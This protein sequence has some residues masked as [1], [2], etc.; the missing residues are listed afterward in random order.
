MAAEVDNGAEGSSGFS[1]S[2]LQERERRGL[3]LMIV[4]L[5]SV[6]GFLI[7]YTVDKKISSIESET[8][9]Y[10][11]MLND[12]AFHGPKLSGEAKSDDKESHLLAKFTEERITG[13]DLKLTSSFAEHAKAV[14]INVSS[15]D[16]DTITLGSRAKAKDGGPVYIEKQLRVDIRETE[17]DK[18]LKLLDRLERSNELIVIKRINLR[19]RRKNKGQVRAQITVSTYIKKESSS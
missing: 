4:V 3:I 13:N 17:F 11:Q 10:R 16:E 9:K 5:L 2:E 8:Q 18:L 1:W 6:G 15:Y 12:L 19:E 14:D 7:F